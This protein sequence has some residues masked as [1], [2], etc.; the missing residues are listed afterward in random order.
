MVAQDCHLE[1]TYLLILE[2]LHPGGYQKGASMT[3]W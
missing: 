3:V 2:L 1:E